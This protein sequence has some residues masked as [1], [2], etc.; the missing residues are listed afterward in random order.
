MGVKYIKASKTFYKILQRNVYKIES[1]FCFD[2]DGEKNFFKK[3]K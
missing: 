1:I 3:Q 2:K